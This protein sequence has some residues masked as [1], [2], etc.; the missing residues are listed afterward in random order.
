MNTFSLGEEKREHCRVGSKILWPLCPVP[1]LS[2]ETDS[3]FGMYP[4]LI[5][6]Y[7]HLSCLTWVA[8]TTGVM[9][10]PVPSW[11]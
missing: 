1:I 7:P 9:Q 11:A 2:P 8:R 3:G 4:I 6:K 5:L 10:A